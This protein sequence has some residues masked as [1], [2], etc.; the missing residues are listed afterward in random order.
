MVPN[1]HFVSETQNFPRGVWFQNH[2]CHCADMASCVKQAS[3]Y[4]LVTEMKTH[5]GLVW[6]YIHAFQ[7]NEHTTNKQTNKQNKLNS[8]I[9]DKC[10]ISFIWFV[11]EYNVAIR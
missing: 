8:D 3:W 2:C 5:C 11:S 9:A 6:G 10:R 4:G 1:C 7:N